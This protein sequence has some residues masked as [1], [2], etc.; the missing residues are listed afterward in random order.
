MGWPLPG[1]CVCSLFF[2]SSFWVVPVV[3]RSGNEQRKKERRTYVVHVSIF[4]FWC[5]AF[6]NSLFIFLV[7]TNINKTSDFTLLAGIGFE[8]CKVLLLHGTHG[9]HVNGSCKSK[10]SATY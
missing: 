9:V 7:R 2:V 6:S 1:G 5:K 10:E 3:P 4:F 8:I